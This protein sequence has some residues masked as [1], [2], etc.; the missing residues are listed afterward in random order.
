MDIR[1]ANPTGF[2]S[3]MFWGVHLLGESV[4]RWGVKYGVKPFGAQEDAGSF[5]FPPCCV[6]M[7]VG[8]IERLC[9]RLSYLF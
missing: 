4:K 6:M 3:W 2:L 7:R 1:H 9:L 8:F 5:E